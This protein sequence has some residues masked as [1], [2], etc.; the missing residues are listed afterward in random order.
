MDAVNSVLIAATVVLALVVVGAPSGS[1]L[2]TLPV[3]DALTDE[4]LNG[5][6]E[7]GVAVHRAIGTERHS[8]VLDAEGVARVPLSLGSVL[9]VTV[10]ATGYE[11]LTVSSFFG[12][13][14]TLEPI[15]GLPLIPEGYRELPWSAERPLL[16][17][18]F[19]GT[20]PAD[21]RARSQAAVVSTRLA[22]RPFQFDIQREATGWV[23][24]VPAEG[25]QVTNR[26]DRERSW[27][28]A[29]ARTV[30]LLAHE[31]GHFDL[32]EVYR[33]LLRDRMLDVVGRGA[34]ATAAQQDLQEQLDT[35]SSEVNRRH[36]QAHRLYDTATAH[37]LDAEGQEEWEE[38]IARWLHHPSRAP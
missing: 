22:V 35:V 12:G 32:S 18:D 23:A 25:L 36:Q 33:R 9:A 31:Q 11:P 8:V 10:D 16:W 5:G 1:A 34:T 26:M 28:L 30:S 37:G 4:P 27:S 17:E 13:S 2:L 6:R 20:P 19:R 7:L 3:V 29:D 24:R 14:G 15:G 38:R 21:A